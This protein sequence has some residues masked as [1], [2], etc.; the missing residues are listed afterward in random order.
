VKGGRSLFNYS[1]DEPAQVR[2]TVEV[3]LGNGINGRLYCAEAPAKLSG[4]PPSTARNDRVDKFV[5]QPNAL[6]AVC[7]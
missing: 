7:P 6:A 2:V 3:K 1:L 5:G 4:N